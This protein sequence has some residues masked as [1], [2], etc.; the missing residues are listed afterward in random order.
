M[1][2]LILTHQLQMIISQKCTVV[3]DCLV[4]DFMEKHIA[5][6]DECLKYKI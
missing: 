3:T 2:H 6:I 1:K 5:D 4:F